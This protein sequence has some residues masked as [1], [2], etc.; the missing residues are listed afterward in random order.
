MKLISLCIIAFTFF[1]CTIEKRIH[2]KG[3]HV[4]WN[5]R[6]YADVNASKETVSLAK[7]IDTNIARTLLVTEEKADLQTI[8]QHDEITKA[9]ETKQVEPSNPINSFQTLTQCGTIT[10]INGKTIAYSHY[11]IE[12]N[13]LFYKKCEDNFSD[14]QNI[15]IED[16]ASIK[17]AK[18]KTILLDS[19]DK[20][21]QNT[22][23]A[24][25]QP[26][27]I[28]KLGIIAFLIGFVVI[29]T[30]LMLLFLNLPSYLSLVLVVVGMIIPMLLM[31]ILS[32]ASLRRM[33]KNPSTYKLK[34][35]SG[36]LAILALITSF[37]G[38]LSFA[39]LALFVI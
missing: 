36:A 31:F 19:A 33:G 6:R 26:K 37:I 29:A 1:Q 8:T 13:S 30:I 17:D 20:P 7:E 23:E 10:L 38:L 22:K 12:E 4:E 16:I 21:G 14:W 15:D 25:N 28:E 5:S 39:V 35:L 34:A 3:Y 2:Q 9:P 27:K 24:E 18:G 32:I 11:K